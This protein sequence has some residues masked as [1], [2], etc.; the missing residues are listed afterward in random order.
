MPTIQTKSTPL[1][2]DLSNK[3]DIDPD[4]G[5]IKIVTDMDAIKNSIENILNTPLGSRVMLPY[6]GSRIRNLLFEP[7]QA[8]LGKLLQVEITSA[9]NTWDDRVKV[10]GVET[11]VDVDKNTVA[12]QVVCDILGLGQQLFIKQINLSSII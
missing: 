5:D 3:F 6:F 12:I 11:Q 9:L 7:I 10:L 4:T 1:Y 2:S 8:N